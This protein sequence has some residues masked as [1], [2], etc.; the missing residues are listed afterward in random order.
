M[1]RLPI[2]RRNSASSV[3]DGP[4]GPPFVGVIWTDDLEQQP[5]AIRLISLGI[6]SA[7]RWLRLHAAD[8]L[9]DERLITSLHHLVFQGVFPQF[10]GSIRG[11][12][13]HQH[14]FEIGFGARRGTPARDVPTRMSELG[15]ASVDLIRRLD[16]QRAANQER[17][18]VGDLLLAAGYVH[19]RLIE[20]HPF[21]NGN[22]RTARL[23]VNY[24]LRRYGLWPL[25]IER[26]ETTA[27]IQAAE[28]FHIDGSVEPFARFLRGLLQRR[29]DDELR[30]ELPPHLR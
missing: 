3:A 23:C 29:Q 30:R 28:Q 4:A 15:A 25:P 10:A 5:E 27:Y 14:N 6:V 18:F 17:D 1:R 2:L 16:E 8:H 12:A 22:G 21:V 20:I 13:A 9:L 7:D 26:P 11:P 24:F 19:C